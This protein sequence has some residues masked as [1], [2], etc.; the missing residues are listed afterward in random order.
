MAGLPYGADAMDTGE[1]MLGTVTVTPVLLESDGTVDPSTENWTS[2]QI[3]TVLANLNT[4]LDWWK[5]LLATKTTKAT[6]DFTIDTTYA[7]TPVPTIYEPIS[8]TSNNYDLW[9]R[10]F[11][12]RLH[13]DSS[14][15]LETNMRE[16]NNSQRLKFGT[17]W[18]FTVFIV[19]SQNDTDGL[20]AAGGSFQKAFGFAGG[21]FFVVP[22]TRP[23]STYAHE[24]GHQFWARDEYPGSAL[25]TARRGYYNTQNTNAI[26]GNPEI[27]FQQQPSIMSSASALDTAY[28]QVTSPASTLA[29]VGWQ[30]TDGDGIF[31]VLDVPLSLDGVGRIDSSSGTYKFTG[32]AAVQ[33][34]A[35]K[36]SSGLADDITINK[37]SRV[38]YRLNSGTWKTIS[39][40]GTS[41]A[42]LNLSIPLEGLQS[43]TIEIRAVDAMT[44]ITSNVF[45]GQIGI[46]PDTTLQ[47]GVQGFAWYDDNRNGQIDTS[48]EALAG[49][50]IQLVDANGSLLQT[51]KRIEPDDKPAGN[52]ASDSYT[53]FVLTAT[54]TD[55]DGRLSIA[56]DANAS[57]GT[58]V[59]QPFSSNSQGFVPTWSGD[60]RQLR[61]DVV[62]KTS[63]VSVDI[64]GTDASYGRLEIYDANGNLL[65]RATT[66]KLLAGK[67][68][69]LSLGRDT[70][71]IAYAIVRGHQSTNI[72]IDNVRIGSANQ[73]VTD[74]NGRYAFPYLP[75]GVY[76][77]QL[78]APNS[79]F[80]FTGASGD[81]RT[82]QLAEGES[83]AH[84]DISA[85]FNGS[86]WQNWRRPLDVNND[87]V[88]TPLD[89]LLIIN[90]INSKG[91]GQLSSLGVSAT[92]Y[93]D[94][95]GD[96]GLSPLDVLLVINSL[97]ARTGS[98]EGESI[99]G[100]AVASS[101]SSTTGTSSAGTNAG[102]LLAGWSSSSHMTA[103]GEG[104]S[105]SLSTSVNDPSTQVTTSSNQ[106]A[107]LNQSVETAGHELIL[108]N[109]VVMAKMK[110]GSW[111]LPIPCCCAACRALDALD[112]NS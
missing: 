94:T 10:E 96:A 23:A 30:D 98:G 40:P 51:Q 19:N 92:P 60:R 107:A 81:K 87:G 76:T 112:G 44:G 59:F 21:L 45:Q 82:L 6:L 65:A 28:T 35:N 1:Y 93:I 3:D 95:N 32:K 101:N 110:S 18:A 37:I 109:A 57:T 15:S 83:S 5:D 25:Y 79:N 102:S 43:G 66:D 16:F 7:N 46:A 42:T 33:T 90:T 14:N 74:S 4:G 84:V 97:N 2:A 75:A 80:V 38:E 58:K 67:V 104:S 91:K 64:I 49:W 20:F 9:T 8:R 103:D 34:L 13:Y 78:V 24:T 100:A 54:G 86:T 85:D 61:I 52:L 62:D 69:T 31:D 56:V 22:S 47:Q 36:N 17:D 106:P 108:D 39:S 11:L 41:T 72:K 53:G 63:F 88:T 71:D 89:V 50:T 27:N 111:S 29:M 73:T 70:K 77:V 99:T 48:D 55:T 105:G 26:D 68:Q 12:T